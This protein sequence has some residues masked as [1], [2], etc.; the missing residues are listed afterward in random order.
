MGLRRKMEREALKR[1]YKQFTRSW[2]DEMT[3]RKAELDGKQVRCPTF[4]EWL[5]TVKRKMAEH[6]KEV[7]AKAAADLEASKSKPD[8]E[9]QE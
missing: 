4:N 9:W 6:N 5:V 3:H 8:L 2:M 7:A 1:V